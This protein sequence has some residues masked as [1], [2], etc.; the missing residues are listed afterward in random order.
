MTERAG[1]RSSGRNGGVTA[2]LIIAAIIM[3]LAAASLIGLALAGTGG[4]ISITFGSIAALA[5]GLVLAASGIEALRRRH[6]RFAVLIPAVMALL[7][8]GY[9]VSSGVYEGLVTVA[10]FAAAAILVALSRDAFDQA[11]P[12]TLQA[13][14]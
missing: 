1:N 4:P 10:I 11:S 13:D 12:E 3:L 14:I 8:L 2:A 9:A 5:M 7:N 6:F